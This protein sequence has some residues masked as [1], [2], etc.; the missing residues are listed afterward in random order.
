MAS[1]IHK[2]TSISQV[3]LTSTKGGGHGTLSNTMGLGVDRV[4][5][6]S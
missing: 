1:G 3:A 4:V 6:V 2:V 5:C